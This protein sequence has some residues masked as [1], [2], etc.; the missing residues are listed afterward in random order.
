MENLM[1]QKSFF[2]FRFIDRKNFSAAEGGNQDDLGS[3]R[4]QR[5]PTQ[6]TQSF[7]E[8]RKAQNWFQRQFSRKMSQDYDSSSGIE[9][10]TAVAAAA[11]AINLLE[12]SE[13]PVQKVREVSETSLTKSKSRMDDTKITTPQPGG[14]SR[15]FSDPGETSLTKIRGTMYDTKIST[16]QQGGVSKRFSDAGSIKI[17]DGQDNK[18]PV[19]IAAN[20]KTP[21][22]AMIPV[23]FIKKAPT[24]GDKR[25]N[26]G[27]GSIKPESAAPKTESVTLTPKRESLTPISDRPDTFKAPVPPA[28]TTREIPTRP[29]VRITK[30]DA[31]E[32]AELAKIKERYEKLHATIGSWENKKKAKA[33]RRLDK[34]ELQLQRRR[35]KSL[36]KYNSEI[37]YIDQIAGEARAQADEKRR[38]EEFKVK[39]KANI[40]RTTGKLPATC[41]CF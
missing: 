26:N 31:W 7:K 40:I 13:V 39:E 34:H 10:A 21:E 6:K 38:K 41:F 27:T 28:E 30:A 1:K 3:S 37:E 8:E 35:V 18:V 14:V 16:P 9:H 12:D 25:F 23:P 4:D 20:E 32:K 33:R 15:R 5:I 24:F 36:E 17:T 2:Q 29:G 11:F 19:T 22:K